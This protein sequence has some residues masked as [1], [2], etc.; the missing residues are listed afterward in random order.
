MAEC[1]TKILN[2][3]SKTKTIVNSALSRL[4]IFDWH[5]L[6]NKWVEVLQHD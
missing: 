6:K 3:F 1:V 4:E 2:N 5:Y